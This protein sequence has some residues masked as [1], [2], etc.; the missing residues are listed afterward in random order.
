MSKAWYISIVF[1]LVLLSI[2]TAYTAATSNV[3]GMFDV[4]ATSDVA[5]PIP[6]V[7]VEDSL[8]RVGK[9]DP[10]KSTGSISLFAA[11]NEYEP[12]QIVVKAPSDTVL[13]N[14]NVTVSDLT[15]PDGDVI[16][17]DTITLYRQQY[18]Y[19]TQGSK[20]R[21]DDTNHPLGPGWYPDALIPFSDPATGQDLTGSMD[22]VPFTVAAGENQPIW[23]DIYTPATAGSGLYTGTATVTSDQGMATVQIQLNV[24]DFALPTTRS[25]KGFTNTFG[26][27]R[28]TTNAIVLLKHRINPK[29]VDLADER[30]LIDS[31]GLDMINAFRT[32]GASYGNCVADPAP[33]VSEIQAEAARHQPDLYLLDAYANEVWDC[34]A[35]FPTFLSWAANLREGGIHPMIVTYPV[36]TLMG[37]DLDHTAGDLWSV[38]PKHYE[39]AKPNI[40]ALLSHGIQLWSYNPLVQDGYSPK[41]TIDFLP[42][43]A[44]I[45]QGFLNQS[46]GA[47]GTKFWRVD[48]WTADPWNNA[49]ATRPDAP[50]EG[51]MVYPGDDVG[52]PNQIVPGVR[53]KWYREGSEDFEYIQML[54]NLGE[55]QF[56]LTIVRSV[57]TDFRTWSG[58]KD[59]LFAARKTLGDKLHS[60][61]AGPTLT[62]TETPTPTDT[63]TPT[64]LPT[65]TPTP[66]PTV[67]PPPSPTPTPLPSPTPIQV[68]LYPIADTFVSKSNP[69]TQFGSRTLLEVDGKPVK[70]SYMKFDLT[71]LAGRRVLSANLNL[72]ISNRSGST[73]TVR[74]G[75]DTSW[76][77]T[78]VTYTTRPALG[79]A[80]ASFSG[81]ASGAWKEI[82]LT[83]SVSA[84]AGQLLSLGIDST[85]SDGL[86]VYS[87]E[88]PTNR[89]QLVITAE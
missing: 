44:R 77:E 58:D 20:T 14:V 35:L 28:N 16:G 83:S 7:W 74:V 26:A 87:R 71:P 52:L 66:T 34:T 51:H 37:P 81:G 54:K 89:P 10:A 73:Q 88:N 65:Q 70:I 64:P 62:P 3:A 68:R 9:T 38:L 60:L 49:E 41:F 86:N 40:D 55:T 29:I 15:G 21:I 30:F 23:V 4:P 56:A 72:R 46:I 78:A 1:L 75:A 39:L 12:F 6:I 57:A 50:G 24:W 17:S 32:S 19:V 45:M 2:T 36:D 11:K 61:S 22:A 47:T 43:N 18:L 8:T 80:V 33:A 67:T 42:I 76:V 53:L 31:Y 13:T 63:P 59:V 84:A 48:N 85:G 82:P 5:A 27:Y 79:E 69:N 25:L